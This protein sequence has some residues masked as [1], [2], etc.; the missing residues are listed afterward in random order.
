MSDAA[1]SKGRRARSDMHKVF[2]FA[3]P[4]F[5]TNTEIGL[6]AGE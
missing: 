3:F 6:S 5:C 1:M 4:H 2:V